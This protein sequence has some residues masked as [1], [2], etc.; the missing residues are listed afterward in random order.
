[1]KQNMNLTQL[2]EFFVK[3]QI[4]GEELLLMKC[5]IRFGT[6]QV[7][8]LI[9]NGRIVVRISYHSDKV[10]HILRRD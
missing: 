8:N 5:W 9:R 3:C 4:C 6:S 10:S 1:M 2:S 7:T